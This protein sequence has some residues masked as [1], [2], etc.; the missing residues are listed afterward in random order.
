MPRVSIWIACNN[1]IALISKIWVPLAFL[2]LQFLEMSHT[3]PLLLKLLELTQ[4]HGLEWKELWT[5]KS[6]R[7]HSPTVT[8]NKFWS[9]ILMKRKFARGNNRNY[10]IETLVF[11]HKTLREYNQMM[12]PFRR[13]YHPQNVSLDMPHP[14]LTPPGI[15]LK[16][17]PSLSHAWP[18]SKL[19]QPEFYYIYI[20]LCKSDKPVQ[21][22]IWG[23]CW[24]VLC[25]LVK[26][27]VSLGNTF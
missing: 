3:L 6:T 23:F 8:I 18:L 1:Q 26:S 25:G 20:S 21:F 13:C 19:N 16:G 2:P 24:D 15:V 5:K 22:P 9:N 27:V 11:V 7:A 14:T 12:V 17:F 10:A 4:M